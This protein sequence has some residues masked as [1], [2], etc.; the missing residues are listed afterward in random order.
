MCV[1]V[2]GAFDRPC[3]WS[4]SCVLLVELG[5]PGNVQRLEDAALQAHQCPFGLATV[6]FQR[7]SLQEDVFCV[8]KQRKDLHVV[9]DDFLQ[10]N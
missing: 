1:L 7:D 10:F 3:F 4:I 8:Q 2:T 9:V 5:A 6:Y